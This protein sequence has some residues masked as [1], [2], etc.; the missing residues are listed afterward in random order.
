MAKSKILNV[1]L[2]FFFRV[3]WPW[4]KKYV[5]PLIRDRVLEIIGGILSKLKSKID[6]YLKGRSEKQESAA[7]E[8]AEEAE[9][10]AKN[11]T[12]ESDRKIQEA[13][14]QVWREV[15]E[16]FREENEL[17]KV[18]LREFTSD[19]DQE[20][21]QQTRSITLDI[22]VTSDKPVLLL[23]QERISL[24]EISSIPEQT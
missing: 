17:L 2:A 24:P 21:N 18:K 7:R 20:I 1:M 19:A 3:V 8:R 10:K 15:A 12:D 6:D 4:I 11:A 22:D 16:Q 13:I 5:W 9:R 23:N 14:A